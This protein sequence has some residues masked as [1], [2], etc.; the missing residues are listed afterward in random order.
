MNHSS[1]DLARRVLGIEA[2]A[3]T[4]LA[5]RLDA[6]FDHAVD[7]LADCKGRVIVAGMG[8]SGIIA[9]KIA[10]TFSSTG[11]PALF[12]HPAEALHG[13]LGA[14][15]G[16]DVVVALS[17]SGET[18]EVVRLLE[19]IKRLGLHLISLTGAPASTL[20]ASSDVD[21]DVCIAEEACPLGLAP[22]TSTTV[23]L[24]LGDALAL[25]LLDR[26]GFSPHDF[27][28]L[29]P[30]GKLGDRL[31]RVSQL[32]HTGEEIPQVSP[33]TAMPEVIY[34]MSRKRLGVT[35][36]TA[37]DGKLL[38]VLSD[39]DLRRL[40][41]RRKDVLHLTAADCLTPNPVTIAATEL[42]AT[43][44]RVMETRRITSLMV[45]D[46]TGR[47]EGVLHLHDLWTTGL[48]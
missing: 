16:G 6:R 23:M 34:E 26:R 2:A 25:A 47:L 43:A 38:G 41:E 9:R 17:Y 42:A 7:L 33:F 36:V 15:V 14:V 37:A 39:G 29:H 12:L 18:E 20:A 35:A 27:A 19:P 31:R 24:A 46:S 4:A 22:T 45:V 21:L 40:L 48:V 10:A 32:M 13:D 5:T 8:K 1:L 11:T 30:A 44:W 28:Q 3:L